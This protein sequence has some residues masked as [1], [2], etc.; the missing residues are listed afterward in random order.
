MIVGPGAQ[1][2]VL[3]GPR[4]RSKKRNS[5]ISP[6]GLTVSCRCQHVHKGCLRIQSTRI[7]RFCRSEQAYKGCLNNK[8]SGIAA[9]CRPRR[10]NKYYRSIQSKR[11][12]CFCRPEQAQKHCT[13]IHSERLCSF[14]CPSRSRWRTRLFGRHAGQKCKINILRKSLSG[15]PLGIPKNRGGEKW[16]MQNDLDGEKERRERK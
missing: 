7:Y 10:S 16:C 3:V 5:G 14:C 9:F 4:A 13:D 2:W 6:S 8:P 15:L 12:L 1:E 11:I